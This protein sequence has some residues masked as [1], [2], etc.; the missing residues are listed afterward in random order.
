MAKAALRSEEVRA[1]HDAVTAGCCLEKASSKLSS[2]IGED[3]VAVLGCTE[4]SVIHESKP[5]S[6]SKICNP[7]HLLAEEICKL[8]F[9][10]N[11]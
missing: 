2:L 1:N 11:V 10:I 8:A 5:L 7:N 4:L 6:H 3:Q 9:Q